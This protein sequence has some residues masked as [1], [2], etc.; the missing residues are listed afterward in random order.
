VHAGG[1]LTRGCLDQAEDLPVFHRN[2]A[3]DRVH[4]HEQGH[5]GF[6]VSFVASL[7]GSG[8]RRTAAVSLW[9]VT[10]DNPGEMGGRVA[11]PI[12]VGRVEE[13]QTLEAARRRAADADPAVV[14]VGGEAGIGKTRW[15]P[16]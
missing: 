10:E 2:A 15:S 16:S 11:S 9:P 7:A 13:L 4:I 1:G 14:L 8:S 5:P 3:V 12:F 6:P